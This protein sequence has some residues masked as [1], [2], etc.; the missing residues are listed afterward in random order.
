MRGN[1]YPR[2]MVDLKKLRNNYDKI[3]EMCKKSN[4][5]VAGVIKG[6]TGLPECGKVAQDAGCDFIAS[7]RLEQLSGLEKHGITIPLMLIRVPMISEA[8]DVIRITDISLNSDNQVL[9][10]L[11]REAKKQGKRHKI[12][13]M[14]DL[15]D[16]RE[17]YW[18]IDELIEAALL[19]E[20]DLKNLELAGIGT[21]LGC[22]GAIAPTNEK[23]KELVDDA[24]AVEKKIGRKLEYISGGATSSLPR[25]V[26]GDLPD[27]INMLRIGEGI[28]LGKDLEELWGY[29]MSFLYKDVFVLQAEVIEVRRKPTHPVGEIMFDAFGN[30]NKYEDVG[31][32]KRALLGVG[33]VD[34][35]YLESIFVRKKGVKILGASSDHTILDVEETNIKVGDV[36]DFDLSYSSLVY[37]TNSPNV[38]IFFKEM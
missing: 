12:I 2:V 3:L 36:I 31:I 13:L 15:G 34:Y 10:A 4:V 17:G 35:A 22:Y 25:I 29:D 7:S 26:E 18:T 20:N 24:E 27:R 32:R 14:D 1:Y 11:N 21:N 5:K 33:K 8:Y 30:K 38:K 28:I 9:K 6:C 23:L 19:V 37:A 16:L